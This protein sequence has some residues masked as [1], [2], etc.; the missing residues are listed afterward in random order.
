[1]KAITK[2]LHHGLICSWIGI[3]I[4]ALAFIF[5]IIGCAKDGDENS[6]SETGLCLAYIDGNFIEVELDEVP[7]YINGG[8]D[9][10]I[11]AIVE[12]ISYPAEARE[13][14]IQGTC[15]VIYEIT[16]QGTVENIIATQDPGGG[17][18][19]SAVETIGNVTT[20]VSFSPGILNGI[21][22]R[23]RKELSIKYK[24]Q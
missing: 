10:F 18:G 12:H 19:G 7:R 2:I 5:I 24:L 21:P 1:M 3:K 11:R 23:V 4:F 20:G 9:G 22:V 8:Y 17:I 14:N 13:N 16:E 15:I 6:I